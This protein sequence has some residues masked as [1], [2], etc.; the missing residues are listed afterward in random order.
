M[1][2]LL[3]WFF[4]LEV[5]LLSL[6]I[7]LFVD[8]MR[9]LVFLDRVLMFMFVVSDLI[10]MFFVSV[11]KLILSLVVCLRIGLV[12]VLSIVFLVMILRMLIVVLLVVMVVFLIFVLCM[13]ESRLC[14]CFGVIV[15]VCFVVWVRLLGDDECGCL[16]DGSFLCMC[17]L[18]RFCCVGFS[19]VNVLWWI[20]LICC[21]LV[22]CRR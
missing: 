14:I 15:L 11:L 6:D 20:C 19:C 7:V 2:R 9:F 1:L 18:M 5:V 13:W 8:L 10:F 21:G 22:V 16:Y 17:V 3:S 4:Y 12:M